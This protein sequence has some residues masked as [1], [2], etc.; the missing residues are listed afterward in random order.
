MKKIILTLGMT[1]AI[2]TSAFAAKNIVCEGESNS[3]AEK[4]RVEIADKKVTVT[5]GF[6]H[7][8]HVFTQLTEVNGLITAPGLAVHYS[9]DY[10]CI[11]DATIIT[12]T[13]EPFGAGYME[14]IQIQHC[15]GGSTPDY[16]C[17]F[18]R[19]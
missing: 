10:G 18:D 3:T 15:R 6:L 2:S 12:E 14:A 9:D 7:T 8:P 19:H 13:R 5:G 4:V 1:L 11:N 16:V 17:G